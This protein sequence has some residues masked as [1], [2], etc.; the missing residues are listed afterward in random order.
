M[1]MCKM[2]GLLTVLSISVYSSDASCDKNRDAS[3][4]CCYHGGR[5]CRAPGQT[6]KKT[7]QENIQTLL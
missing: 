5:H 1:S 2:V 7:V 4:M 3:S 6:L